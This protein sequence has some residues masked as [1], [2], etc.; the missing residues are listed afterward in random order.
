MSAG[1]EKLPMVVL[2]VE[3]RLMNVIFQFLFPLC[4]LRKKLS[5]AGS[6]ICGCEVSFAV[7]QTLS[8]CHP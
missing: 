5:G 6:A 8:I 4:M 1:C 2:H 3:Q 7:L